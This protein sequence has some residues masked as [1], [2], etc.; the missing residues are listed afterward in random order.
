[1]SPEAVEIRFVASTE[2]LEKVNRLRELLSHKAPSMSLAELVDEMAGAAL[3]KWDPERRI[4]R[5]EKGQPTPAPEMK[6]DPRCE[7]GTDLADQS[8]EAVKD[9]PAQVPTSTLP[10]K[11]PTRYIPSAIRQEVLRRDDYA[12]TYRDPEAG[13]KCG[14]RFRLELD[15]R[16]PWAVGGQSKA[17]DLRVRCQPHNQLAAIQFYGQAKMSKFL[18]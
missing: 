14:S 3:E 8:S 11:V 5:P 13:R 6:A 17:E 1:V 16:T 18:R 7:S 12:C 9:Y 15:H 2:L 4:G 10:K